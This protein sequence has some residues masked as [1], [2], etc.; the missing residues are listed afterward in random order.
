MGC[1]PFWEHGIPH[2]HKVLPLLV[3]HLILEVP[4]PKTRVSQLEFFVNQNVS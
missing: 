2:I 4:Y 3:S 1:E